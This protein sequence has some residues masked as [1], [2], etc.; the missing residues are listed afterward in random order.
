MDNSEKVMIKSVASMFSRHREEILNN[1]LGLFEKHLYVKEGIEFEIFKNAF[2]KLLNDFIKYLPNGDFQ[3][4]YAGNERIAREIA[5]NDISYKNIIMAFHLFEESY[6]DIFAREVSIAD[7]PGYLVAVDH[8]HHTTIGILTGV[9][10]EVRDETVLAL[11]ELAELRDYQTGGHLERTR[12]YAVLLAREAGLDLE[13]VHEIYRVGP[14]HDIGK[15]A[16]RDS[17]LLKNGPLDDDEFAEMKK[18][19]LIGAQTIKKIIGNQNVSRGYLLTAY[20][21]ALYHHEKYDGSG[22]PEGLRGDR[23]P[24]VARIF[25]IGDCYDALVSKRPYKGSMPHEEAVRIIKG[26]SGSHFDPEVVE[27]FLKHQHEIR[28]IYSEHTKKR[29]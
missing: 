26:E 3:E 28:R 25:S 20:D 16:I 7:S 21:I 19:T 4:Y 12:D 14:L 17:I 29:R 9:Y 10:F 6:A 8:L 22:Y 1:W 23:I 5:Y 27:L 24:V 15:I 13:M 11:A 18:H 2:E